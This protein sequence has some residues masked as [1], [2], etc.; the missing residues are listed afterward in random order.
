[1]S[2]DIMKICPF[3]EG[4]WMWLKVY[5]SGVIDF[6]ITCIY[7]NL[8]NWIAGKIYWDRCLYIY[9][10]NI[11]TAS[12]HFRLGLDSDQGITPIMLFKR[13]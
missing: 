13:I 7:C 9:I 1:M 10:L 8:S 4:D 2:V 12:H 11:S 6:G 5:L 3:S